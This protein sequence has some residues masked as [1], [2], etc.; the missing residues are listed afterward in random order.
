MTQPTED[1]TTRAISDLQVSF[2]KDEI[3]DASEMQLRDHLRTLNNVKITN[4]NVQHRAV[5][6]ALTINHIQMTRVIAELESRNNKTQFWFL[7]LAAGSLA[8]GA[9]AIIF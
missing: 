4:P 9:L 5:I 7:V 8:I 3:W 6:Q 2:Q 1:P